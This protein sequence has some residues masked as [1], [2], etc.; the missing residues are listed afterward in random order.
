VATE[1]REAY[2]WRQVSDHI[3][4][5]QDALQQLWQEYL[6]DKSAR[7]ADEGYVIG[8][9]NKRLKLPKDQA[10]GRYLRAVGACADDSVKVV[11]GR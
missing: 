10:L 1:T 8:E 9:I 5:A 3:S 6:E 2:L 7:G 11:L 4:A